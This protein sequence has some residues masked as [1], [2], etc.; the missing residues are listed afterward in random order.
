MSYSIYLKQI[1]NTKKIFRAILFATV[2]ALLFYAF[3]LLWLSSIG[4]EL[5]EIL[6]DTAQQTEESSFLGFL[7]NIGIWLWV[8]SAAISFFGAI[9]GDFATQGRL[10]ELLFLT[11]TLSTMLAIDDFFMIHDRYIDQ[12]LCYLTYAILAGALLAR[13]FKKIVEIDGFSFLFAGLLLALSILT[14]LIQSHIPLRY[15]YTQVFEE[16]FKFIGAAT[17]LYFISQA[18]SLCPNPSSLKN[19]RKS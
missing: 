12:N 4:F 11:G 18:A 2:P 15:S 8:S 7:S 14:D 16:G 19:R 6:R 1:F 13:H 17:W 5:M 10:R 3:S 9:T